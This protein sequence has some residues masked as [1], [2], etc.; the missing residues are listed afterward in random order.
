MINKATKKA[1]SDESKN[2][3]AVIA[4]HAYASIFGKQATREGHVPGMVL[5]EWAGCGKNDISDE[6]LT[7]QPVDHFETDF[8]RK[9]IQVLTEFKQ[10]YMNCPEVCDSLK[11]IVELHVHGHAI[12][13][14]HT[15]LH[16][17]ICLSCVHGQCTH[18]FG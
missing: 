5:C 11:L 13:H 7:W 1:T 14:L 3:P 8:L 18:L 4:L 12:F 9:Y 6:E 15:N 16:G 17:C 10:W 2:H